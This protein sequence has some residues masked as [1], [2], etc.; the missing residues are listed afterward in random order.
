M[1]DFKKRLRKALDSSGQVKYKKG[2]YIKNSGGGDQVVYGA[3]HSQGG[4]LRNP[5]VELEGGGYTP[6]G[7]A[8]AGE[9]ITTIYDNGGN[10]Q[11]FYMSHKN[12]IAQR[13][14]QAKAENGGTLPQ[15]TKQEFAKLNESMN[16]DGSPQQVASNGGMR[17]YFMGGMPSQEINAAQA[18]RISE[19]DLIHQQTARAYGGYRGGIPEEYVHGGYH[20][21]TPTGSDQNQS[22]LSQGT[23]QSWGSKAWEVITN[24]G[25][26]A[27]WKTTHHNTP[28]PDYFSTRDMS[29]QNIDNRGSHGTGIDFATSFVNPAAIADMVWTYGNDVKTEGM[30]TENAAQAAFMLAFRKRMPGGSKEQAMAAFN[31]VR[32]KALPAVRNTSVATTS[33][34]PMSGRGIPGSPYGSGS[35]IP[36]VYNPA[37]TTG[38]GMTWKDHAIGLGAGAGIYALTNEDENTQ[39]GVLN[40]DGTT[41]TNPIMRDIGMTQN[42]WEN[43][44]TNEASPNGDNPNEPDTRRQDFH[45]KMINNGFIFDKVTGTYK[46]P[47][48]EVVT[49]TGNTGGRG[50]NGSDETRSIQNQLLE[51]GYNLDK[52][53]PDGKMGPETQGALDTMNDDKAR[54]AAGMGVNLEDLVWD[55]TRTENNYGTDKGGWMPKEGA[56]NTAFGDV[57]KDGEWSAEEG[58][59]NEEGDLT[60]AEKKA[61]TTTDENPKK[62]F[63]DR[64]GMNNI[65]DAIE[66]ASIMKANR[67]AQEQNR[68]IGDLTVKSQKVKPGSYTPET[69]DLGADKER[70]SQLTVANIKAGQ[71]SGKSMA[72]IIAAQKAGQGQLRDLSKTESNL[73]K[74][75]NN[76]AKK[77]NMDS[78]FKADTLNMS[79][80]R[81]DQIANNDAKA[82]MYKNSIA[83]SQSMRDAI[84]TKIK[85]GKQLKAAE[86]QMLVINAAIAG[87]TGTDKRKGIDNIRQLMNKGYVGQTEGE[88]LIT[89]IESTIEKE[90]K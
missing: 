68:K 2:G 7:Q 11:E 61:K 81:M 74:E 15:Q 24:P 6:N 87:G 86:N 5:N 73:Q 39:T 78:K 22:M 28:L 29:G 38:G 44:K 13:Y 35:G 52:Y 66:I 32:N 40:V 82:S 65:T 12:G 21:P 90:S 36:T 80:D 88:Q 8:K 67:Y 63:L 18:G 75:Q 31:K 27:S 4:V 34:L 62:N 70:T 30:T 64:I 60:P 51:Q 49:P 79:N 84:S 17:K 50:N 48:G 45:D 58:Y 41:N 77:M 72:S 55:P 76:F 69:V 37:T 43:N 19:S 46:K 89:N 53:G 59:Y 20:P 23:P 57:W 42:E 54:A 1:S 83:L 26:A 33:K 10:P 56:V 3:T 47:T 14:L 85:D 9:V 16:P 25:A 71:Q